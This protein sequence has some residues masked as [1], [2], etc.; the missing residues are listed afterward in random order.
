MLHN[1][2][3]GMHYWFGTWSVSLNT[4]N[5]QA[6][7]NAIL[8]SQI[9]GQ[10]I[11]GLEG[12]HNISHAE[13]LILLARIKSSCTLMWHC[14]ADPLSLGYFGLCSF[15]DESEG[16]FSDPS[17]D[18]LADILLYFSCKSL[19]ICRKCALH[20]PWSESWHSPAHGGEG[21]KLFSILLE[22]GHEAFKKN[23]LRLP[24]RRSHLLPISTVEEFLLCRCF[25]PNY[26]QS[27]V[28]R[29]GTSCK[30]APRL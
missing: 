5:M 14:I 30:A 3:V 15:S 8:P 21:L 12:I 10:S 1:L 6:A 22:A 13:F 29:A 2:F 17:V 11:G 26:S 18:C 20:W 28:P 27:W 7:L 16:N 25:M 9:G 4:W 19:C 24:Q 23:S